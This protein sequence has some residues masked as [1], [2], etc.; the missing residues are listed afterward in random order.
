MLV[1][2]LQVPSVTLEGILMVLL[3]LS[4]HLTDN[5]L[6]R[7]PMIGL[8]VFG[9]WRVERL[10]RYSPSL[11]M[12]ITMKTASIPPAYH[13]KEIELLLGHMMVR[14]TCGVGCETVEKNFSMMFMRL[15]R[16]GVQYIWKQTCIHFVLLQTITAFV[17]DLFRNNYH[18]MGLMVRQVH[19]LNRPI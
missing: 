15:R 11:E 3:P 13:R 19:S 12:H 10:R 14:Y 9:V 4:F 2:R 17:Y 16:D 1:E 5:G 8:S 6:S 7:V 18:R